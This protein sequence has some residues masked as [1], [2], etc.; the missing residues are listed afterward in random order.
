VTFEHANDFARAYLRNTADGGVYVT[1]DNLFDM[2]DRFHLLVGVDEPKA[3]FEMN[4]QVVWVNRSPSPGSGLER[5]VGVAWLDMTPE[6]K[7]LIKSIVY[8]VLDELT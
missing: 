7:K 3:S 4:V 2:G 5:G 8:G 1:T 6:K